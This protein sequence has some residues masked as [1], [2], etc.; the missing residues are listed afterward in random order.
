MLEDVLCAL[1]NNVYSATS[2]WNALQTLKF[3]WSNMSFKACASLLI[4]LLDDLSIDTSGI[5]KSPTII[6]LLSI[7]PFMSVNV[8]LIY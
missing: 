8:C 4:F 7:S 5:L 3:V 1:E 6:L 2:G